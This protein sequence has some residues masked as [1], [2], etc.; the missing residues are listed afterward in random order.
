MFNEEIAPD[1]ARTNLINCLKL[2]FF[3]DSFEIL[4]SQKMSVLIRMYSNL[5]L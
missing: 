1:S 5:D 2:K 3:Y 4:F